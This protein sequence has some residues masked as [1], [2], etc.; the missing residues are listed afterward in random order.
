MIYD[1][2]TDEELLRV[3]DGQAGLIKALAERLEMRMR[4]IEEL[5]KPTQVEDDRQLKLF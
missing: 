1:N 2:L 4:D 5:D 3:A